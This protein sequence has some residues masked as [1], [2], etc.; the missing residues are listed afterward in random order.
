LYRGI[1]AVVGVALIAL[2]AST[3]CVVHA[4]GDDVTARV[5]ANPLV[6]SLELSRPEV[7]AGSAVAA[8][9]RIANLG[10]SRIEAVEVVI[11][12]DEESITARGGSIENLHEMEGGASHSLSQ[13]LQPHQPGSYV[14][15]AKASGTTS[16]GAPIEAESNAVIL[17]V[18]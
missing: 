1:A 9:V 4:E 16:T 12:Y 14:I 6:L 3:P 15:A 2:V 8:F 7:R 5:T 17:T 18:R 11:L 13:V 10:D